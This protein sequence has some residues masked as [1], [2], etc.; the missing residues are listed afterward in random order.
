VRPVR[1]LTAIAA[2]GA[3]ATFAVS[4]SVAGPASAKEVGTTC[5]QWSANNLLTGTFS[6][7]SDKAATGGSGT[8]TTG[9]TDVLTI[10][11]VNGRTTQISGPG[12][13]SPKRTEDENANHQCPPQMTEYKW[14]GS[15]TADTTG[16]IPVG[17]KLSGEVCIDFST[18]S[19]EN[20]PHTDLSIT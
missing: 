19:S 20:E 8:L 5:E 13:R 4:L 9:P 15:V 11:W 16:S 6:E 18:A 1:I 7:C 14:F 12:I 10:S 17:G 3:L 2:G